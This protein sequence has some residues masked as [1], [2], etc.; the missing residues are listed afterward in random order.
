MYK[1]KY[2]FSNILW[3][4]GHL[5]VQEAIFPPAETAANLFGP[6]LG[7]IFGRALANW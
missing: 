7:G 2:L 6:K 3:S 5:V 1:V 4:L